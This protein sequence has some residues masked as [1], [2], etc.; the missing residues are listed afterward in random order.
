MSLL[1]ELLDRF[2]SA[3]DWPMDD[4]DEAPV[5]PDPVD[6]VAAATAVAWSCAG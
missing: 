4:A 3:L 5:T 1:D 2:D 6:P